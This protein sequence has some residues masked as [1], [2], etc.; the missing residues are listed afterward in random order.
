MDLDAYLASLLLDA[1]DL[2]MLESAMYD[3]YNRN[4]DEAV[5]FDMERWDHLLM[6]IVG[7][8]ADLDGASP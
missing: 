4:I 6:R 7:K 8:R 2:Q 1:G 3:H 5:Q